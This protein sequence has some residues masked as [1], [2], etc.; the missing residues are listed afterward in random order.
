MSV[1][2]WQMSVQKQDGIMLLQSATNFLQK[3][4]LLI[5]DFRSPNGESNMVGLLWWLT[6]GTCNFHFFT[7]TSK[8]YFRLPTYCSATTTPHCHNPSTFS[9]VSQSVQLIKR[10]PREPCTYSQHLSLDPWFQKIVMQLGK[11]FFYFSSHYLH[12]PSWNAYS[13]ATALNKQL[14]DG[15]NP[16]SCILSLRKINGFEEQREQFFQRWTL[17]GPFITFHGIDGL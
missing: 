17:L 5:N 3:L 8:V 12:F 9:F 2:G 16:A 4:N 13:L 7:R 10:I 1:L 6:P 11:I 14:C 15:P